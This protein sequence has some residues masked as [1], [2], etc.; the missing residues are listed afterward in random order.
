MNG[1]L[2]VQCQ[3]CPKMCII[4]DGQSGDCRVRVNR[5]GR[6]LATTFG[7]PCTLHV[8]PIE[9]KPL[10]HFLPGS[11]AF[12]LATAGCNLHCKNCQNWEI[13]QAGPLDIDSRAV[14]PGA[15]VELARRSGSASIA[16]TYSDPT[17]FYEYALETSQLAAAAGLRN[18]QVTAAYINPDPLRQ[19][20]QVTHAANADLKFI[21]DSLYRS[22]CD[23]SLKPVQDA[24]VIYKEQGVWL[25][26]TNL[27]VP[28]LNDEARSIERLCQWMVRE[29]G[30][31]VPLH[32]SRFHPLYRLRH[33]PVTPEETLARAHRIASDCGIRYCYLGNVMGSPHEHTYCPRDRT[34]LIRRIGYII[35]ENRLTAEGCCPT[36]GEKIPG[37][38]T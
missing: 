16:Y 7:R 15:I 17:V 11:Q 34:L 29:L 9:K 5:G 19:L 13:S 18:V 21:D 3:I 36:C 6:L 24:L 10:F 25:E 22:I 38:W 2:E 27:I 33:L 35:K 31:D 26:V 37:V 30:P 1:S 12:S 32:F 23:A 14:P 20:C 8:D 28:T 4:G